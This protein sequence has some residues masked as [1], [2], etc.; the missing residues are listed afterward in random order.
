MHLNARSIPFGS[1]SLCPHRIFCN[2]FKGKHR[3]IPPESTNNFQFSTINFQLK[4]YAI[5][6]SNRPQKGHE[7]RPPKGAQLYYGQIRSMEKTSFKNCVNWY[8][9]TAPPKPVK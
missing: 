2:E 9:V 5:K 4:S 7:Q 6:V 8:L 1:F 3:L